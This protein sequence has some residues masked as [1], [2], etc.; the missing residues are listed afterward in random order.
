MMIGSD[1]PFSE[2]SPLDQK[3]EF[4]VSVSSSEWTSEDGDKPP[5]AIEVL[6]EG[7]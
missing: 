2:E 6:E 3:V 1:G 4:A 7:N 5:R